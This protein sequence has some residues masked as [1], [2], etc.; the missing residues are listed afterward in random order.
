MQTQQIS[1]YLYVTGS[2]SKDGQIELTCSDTG[3]TCPTC[4]K[5]F[6]KVKTLFSFCSNTIFINFIIL[7]M[8]SFI[9][10][11]QEQHVIQHLKTHEGKQWEC[12]TCSKMF[13]TKY[14]LKKHKRLHSGEMPYKCKICD[15][16][17]TFQQSYHK[18][19][20]YHKDEKPY[21]CA[22]CGRSFKELSTLHNHERIHTGEKPFACETCGML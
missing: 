8:I 12:D 20:F 11:F 5:K 21:N 9:F 18:H 2:L 22:T 15:K 3:Y 10:S 13:T 1:H 4:G 14:F 16:S 7:L 17:F 19:R 6:K